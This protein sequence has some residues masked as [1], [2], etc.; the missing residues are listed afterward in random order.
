MANSAAWSPLAALRGG[1]F[2][3]MTGFGQAIASFLVV[4]CGYWLYWLIAV[5]LIEPGLDPEVAT[6][7]RQE[8][9]EAAAAAPRR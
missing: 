1:K 5:P 2:A 4:F 7:A 3:S 9:L 6:T 8:D